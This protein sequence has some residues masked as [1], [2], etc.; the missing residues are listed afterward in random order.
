[1]IEAVGILRVI[2]YSALEFGKVLRLGSLRFIIGYRFVGLQVYSVI[3]AVFVAVIVGLAAVVGL[4]VLDRGIFVVESPIEHV[5]LGKV[6]LLCNEGKNGSI[7][8]IFLHRFVLLL[9]LVQKVE[10][11]VVRDR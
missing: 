7:R 1:M 3:F 11:V 8:R 4:E 5:C 2:L 9:K 10:N 6:F